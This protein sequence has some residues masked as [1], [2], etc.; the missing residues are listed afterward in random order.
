LPVPINCL[1][2]PPTFLVAT[3]RVRG[4]DFSRLIRMTNQRSYLT[5]RKNAAPGESKLERQT[6][7]PSQHELE[8]LQAIV[9]G[10][11]ASTGTDFFLS[12][13]RHLA[14]AL[15][16]PYAYIAECLDAN[17]SHARI[18]AH[19]K[20]DHY[21]PVR[22]YNL[23]GSPCEIVTR[24]ETYYQS[25]GLCLD[26]PREVPVRLGIQGY[27]G[28]PLFD[29]AGSVIGHLV[30]M[31]DKP[32]PE[33]PHGL[34]IIQI[35]AARAGAE[36]ERMRMEAALRFI[37]AGTANKT[38]EAFFVS[39][40]QH[41][42]AALE[43]PYA[44]V[45]ECIDAYKTRVRILAYWKGDPGNAGAGRE[46]DLDG[47]P[48]E[49]VSRG[50]IYYQP[51]GIHR[52]FPRD[53][54]LVNIGIEGYLGVPLCD[55]LGNVIGHLVAMDNKPMPEKPH[56]LP[57]LQIFAARAGA[58]LE[59]MRVETALR[60]VAEGTAN[61]TGEGFFTS[62]VQH[63]SAALPVRQAFITE[64]IG[65]A[66][67]RLR[68]LAYWQDTRPGDTFEYDLAGTI[69]ERVLAAED[70]YYEGE[71]PAVY[72]PSDI[73]PFQIEAQSYLGIAMRDSAGNALGH[74]AVLHDKR[75]SHDARSR[76]ILKIFAAR[77]GAEL[78]RQRAEAALRQ[79]LRQEQAM[80]GQLVQAGK[81]AA[82]GRLVASVAHELN[83]PLQV[84]ENALYLIN[85]ANRDTFSDQ[86]ENNLALA[87]AE[88]ERMAAL[89]SRLRET[90]RPAATEEFRPQ[91]LNDL[92][93]E[94]QRL[95]T[96]HL[97]HHHVHFVFE[98]DPALPPIRAIRD[99]L[100]Q[101]ILNLFLNGAEAMPGGGCLVTR[102]GIWPDANEVW[103]SVT[104]SGVGIAPEDLAN[105]FDPF[106]TTKPT[107]TG[108]GLAI[109]YDIVQR[110]AGRIEVESQPGYGTT[111]TV[112]LPMSKEGNS[113]ELIFRKVR[114]V[115]HT[116]R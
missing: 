12:L 95:I 69:C 79:S 84:I 47:T 81:L 66:K 113:E 19:W 107:G 40:V 77:A 78:E 65:E 6:A 56:G 35:F 48:C 15:E 23:I 82:M 11:A 37:A 45:A 8:T 53:L 42:S 76:S 103:F 5:K 106:F 116:L 29:S 20:K 108:L 92:I 85:Q 26:F 24:G 51:N 105:V 21:A 90:Y 7:E 54:P 98:A 91:L 36:L 80:R 71:V 49:I 22:E 28:T 50:E 88:T 14:A 44:L 62:L 93:L 68:V 38:G 55:S 100:K 34:S 87:L 96:T 9:E 30:V 57:I 18:L 31:D 39:L 75:L 104:D 59:R 3:A 60:F 89:I 74:L 70:C 73:E 86:S 52:D 115:H 1:V 17:K 102:A 67:E 41:L 58:E 97:R 10:T 25:E 63:L 43:V 114:N 109:T 99:Q 61:Q 2:Q 72:S 64:C 4:N 110:H 112:W 101:V 94:V 83:N 33:K 111:F 46:Y 32:L 16:V 27:L 13:V